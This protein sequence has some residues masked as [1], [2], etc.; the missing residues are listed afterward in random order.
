MRDKRHTT[1]GRDR[2][3]VADVAA[4]RSGGDGKIRSS[5]SNRM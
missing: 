1:E 5:N 3:I 4:E 2:H